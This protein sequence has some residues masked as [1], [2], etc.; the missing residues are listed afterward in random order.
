LSQT[1]D[2]LPAER[3]QSRIRVLRSQRVLLD[4]DLA[5]RHK[6]NR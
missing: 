6:V 2:I 5:L 3:I 4:A 1:A